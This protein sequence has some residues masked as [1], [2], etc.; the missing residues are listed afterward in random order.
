MRSLR[1]LGSRLRHN[2]VRV[3]RRATARSVLG[4]RAGRD[5]FWLLVRVGPRIGDLRANALPFSREPGPVALVDL[6]RALE[7]AGDDP[8]VAG[9]VLRFESGEGGFGGFARAATLRRAIVRLRE[10]GKVVWAWGETYDA[11]AYSVACAADRVELPPS[12]ALQLVGLRSQQWFVRE[13]LDRLGVRAEVVRIGSSKAAAEPLLRRS[14]SEE[15]REQV[16]AFQSEVFDELV[17]AIATGR[18]LDEATVRRHIDEG[19][20]AAGE[21]LER[22][23][24]DACRYP[25][26][27]EAALCAALD[28]EPA[29]ETGD[30]AAPLVEA[31]TYFALHAGDAGWRPLGGDLPRLAYVV[32]AGAIHRGR[33]SRGI[34]SQR[35]AELFARLMR[36]D[37]V[38]GVVLRIDSPGGDAV[39]SDL[40]HRSVERLARCKPV[41]VSMGEV[42][43][44]GGYY[45][46]AGAHRVLAER[47]T[48][49]GSI[50]VIGGKLDLSGLYERLGVDVD[51][52]ERGAR[53]GILSETRGFT[54][55]ERNALQREM[56][57]LYATF[58][59]RVAKG[60]SLDAGAVESAAQGRIWSGERARALGLVDALGGPLEALAEVCERAGVARGERFLLDIHPRRAV[61]A[62]LRDWLSALQVRER[63]TRSHFD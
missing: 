34:A 10:S 12:G 60:R 44:S 8:R 36:D 49:T 15:Q 46:A 62:G 22:G 27:V 59:E 42:A 20:H 55:D 56:R 19:P 4:K 32:A 17:S 38:R 7:V 43:A 16:D 14:M 25:D 18:D 47:A 50:G 28:A 37:E 13:L 51:A 30:A 58:K 40:L 33:A 6:L 48:L 5:R 31:S 35:Y 45:L 21:A 41:V 23:L 26:E 57:A 24:L 29:G 3:V 11:L 54:P 53:A 1:G 2:A 9:V 61:L 63:A 52:V 39:A